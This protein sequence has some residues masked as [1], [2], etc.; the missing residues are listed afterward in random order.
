MLESKQLKGLGVPERYD[1]LSEHTGKG[2]DIETI[3]SSLLF[4]L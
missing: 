2:N 4:R 3:V 1:L